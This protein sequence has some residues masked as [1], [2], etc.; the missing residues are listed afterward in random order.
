MI[1]VITQIIQITV[2]KYNQVTF[3]IFSKLL[4]DW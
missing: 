3:L 2:G 4:L 1:E